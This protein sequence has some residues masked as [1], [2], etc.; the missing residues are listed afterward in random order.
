VQTAVEWRVQTAVEWRVQ[1]A[2]ECCVAA[3]PHQPFLTAHNETCTS[4]I[5]S[6][7]TS[8]TKQTPKPSFD[9]LVDAMVDVEMPCK[10]ICVKVWEAWAIDETYL[11]APGL[12]WK[13][14]LQLCVEP[15]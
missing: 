11:T 4:A 8:R 2:V 3:L 5:G 9:I 12:R 13:V 6:V 1:T 14:C 7:S 10:M 15:L